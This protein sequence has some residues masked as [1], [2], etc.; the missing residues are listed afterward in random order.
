MLWKKQGAFDDELRLLSDADRLAFGGVGIAGA[1]LPATK[2]YFAV[3]EGLREHGAQL[4]PRLEALLDKATPAGR[5]YAAELLTHASAEEL[6]AAADA[7]M[8]HAYAPYS[9]FRV[10]AALLA[11][12]GT[13]Y[14]GCNVE[15]SSFPA[16]RCAERN[17]IGAAIHA[18][19]QEFT[20]LVIV[21]EADTPTPPCGLCRQALV[22]FAPN[23]PVTS[24]GA[25]GTSALLHLAAFLCLVASTVAT[26]RTA[27]WT[28]TWALAATLGALTVTHPTM[29]AVDAIRAKNRRR[30]RYSILA[31]GSACSVNC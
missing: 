25:L 7:A 26:L 9:Q 30:V 17:A 11:A 6:R 10:G 21:T 31:G 15:N 3:E 5:I 1:L 24:F 22:E 4:R 18:G 13:V 12:D 29:V 2:A 28:S 14:A 23:L 8:K 19:R 20:A 27:P 16:G